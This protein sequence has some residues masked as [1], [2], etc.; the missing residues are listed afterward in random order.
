MSDVLAAATLERLPAGQLDEL[1][2]RYPYDQDESWVR[3]V[4]ARDGWTEANRQ[5]LRWHHD[6]GAAEMGALMEAAGVDQVETPRAA[7]DL[8]RLAYEVY[9]PPERFR[10][11]MVTLDEDRVRVVVG[12]CPMF[13]KIDDAGGAG[14]TACGSWHH[15]RGWFDGM[16]VAVEDNVHAEQ[17]WGE[18]ACVTEVKFVL[19]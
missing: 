11:T 17:T 19:P 12:R 1:R 3:L 13:D 6:R 4:A 5:F 7:A 10:A 9:M 15:R 16:G 14:V 18:P 8:L 2:Q